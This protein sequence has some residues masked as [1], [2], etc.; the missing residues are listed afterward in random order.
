MSIAGGRGLRRGENAF[1][2]QGEAFEARR[3]LETKFG[4]LAITNSLLLDVNGSNTMT[5]G[6]NVYF[7]LLGSPDR[8]MH[9]RQ[10]R[11]QVT[12]A[13]AGTRVSC[14][15]YAYR[16]TDRSLVLLPLSTFAV[17][18]G[19]TGLISGDIAD[20]VIYPDAIYFGAVHCTGGAINI[21]AVQ[22]SRALWSARTLFTQTRL[23]GALSIDAPT[24]V[25]GLNQAVP[26]IMFLTRLGVD[27]L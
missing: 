18:G 9:L 23:P 14:G 8:I 13:L 12:T 3:E 2:D 15:I 4:G 27:L 22:T 17:S 5:I 21:A 11:I 16:E 6:A 1:A 26:S 10:G 24:R 19:A 25:S 7:T 20:C